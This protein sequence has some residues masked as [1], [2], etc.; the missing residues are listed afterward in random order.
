LNHHH[1]KNPFYIATGYLNLFLYFLKNHSES[2]GEDL[3]VLS[4]EV[5]DVI[6]KY[7]WPGNVRQLENTC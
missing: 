5:M 4:Q 6:T 1:Q 3:R 7:D 2:L